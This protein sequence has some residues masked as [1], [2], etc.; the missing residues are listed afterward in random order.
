MD[1]RDSIDATTS[2]T[3]MA[4]L[5]SGHLCGRRPG[6]GGQYPLPPRDQT[7]QDQQYGAAQGTAFRQHQR[8]N[9][10]H[11]RPADSD[12]RGLSVLDEDGQPD[13]NLSVIITYAVLIS[14][15]SG[16]A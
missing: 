3:P 5:K 15:C 9:G 10:R 4:L 8:N 2:A 14:F 6:C 1:D 11:Q 12:W 16:W 13:N 7:D